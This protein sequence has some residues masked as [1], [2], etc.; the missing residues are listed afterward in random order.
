MFGFCLFNKTVTI[1][2]SD[3]NYVWRL[4]LA[5]GTLFWLEMAT[6]MHL[7]VV[8]NTNSETTLNSFACTTVKPQILVRCKNKHF[9]NVTVTQKFSNMKKNPS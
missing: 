1:S 8:C 4:H 6:T 3:I 5:S 7:T 9:L 2:Q